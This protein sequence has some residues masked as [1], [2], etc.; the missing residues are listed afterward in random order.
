MGAANAGVPL[1]LFQQS[2]GWDGYF[3]AMAGASL[4]VVALLLP[5][6]NAKSYAQKQ[7]EAAAGAGA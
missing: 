5:L 2:F 7:V 1:A 3:M 6:A 4:L